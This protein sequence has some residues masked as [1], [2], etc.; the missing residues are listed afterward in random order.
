MQSVKDYRRPLV[1]VSVALLYIVPIVS[2]ALLGEPNLYVNIIRLGALLGYVSI[3][4]STVLSNYLREVR[5]I[6]GRP[7]LKVHHWFAILG[8]IL[9][10]V[11]P[12]TFAI[13]TG[14]LLVMVPDFSSWYAF[15]S[16]AGRPALYLAYVAV[17]A[18]LLRNRVKK[19]WRFIHGLMYVVL[20]FA[21]VHGL[22]IG[23]NF[24]NPVIAGLFGVMLI[25]SYAVGILKRVSS[26]RKQTGKAQS[27]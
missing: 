1:L 17:L 7:F 10:T 21:F 20:T 22:L 13:Y 23:A 15:W 27:G 14:S 24:A 11:H 16:L 19:Y 5:Q 6:F 4:V 8:V 2:V 3:F 12:V 25:F 26:R 9:I 18:G